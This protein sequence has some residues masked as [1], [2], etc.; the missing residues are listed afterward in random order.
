[1]ATTVRVEIRRVL[2]LGDYNSIG[3][4]FGVEEEVPEDKKT[5]QHL[6]DLTS[7]LE[8]LM[9]QK[10]LDSGQIELDG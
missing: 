4:T 2:N 9:T 8:D 5:S 10:L 3:Y 1:M 7:R 6:K